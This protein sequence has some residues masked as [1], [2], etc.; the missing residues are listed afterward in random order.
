M[1]S[2]RHRLG[3]GDFSPSSSWRFLSLPHSYFGVKWRPNT[4]ALFRCAVVIPSAVYPSAVARN[5]IRRFFYDTALA[6]YA[7]YSIDVVFYIKKPVFTLDKTTLS[8]LLRDL[9][10]KFPR[11]Q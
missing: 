4:R 9:S 1:I 11:G 5:S 2:R 10:Q 3:V 6:L 8:D 7:P